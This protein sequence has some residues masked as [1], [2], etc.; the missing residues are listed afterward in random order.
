[1]DS[2]DYV[3]ASGT[4][5]FIASD[6]TKSFTVK[7]LNDGDRESNETATLAL[8]NPSNPGGNARLGGPSTAMLMIID[9]DPAV[10]GGGL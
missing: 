8:S 2:S 6:T 3:S 7:I 5:T 9:D 10:L 1:A 4:L